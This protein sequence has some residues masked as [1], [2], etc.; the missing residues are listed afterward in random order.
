[1]NFTRKN[2]KPCEK[3]R[4]KKARID[5]NVKALRGDDFPIYNMIKKAIE[6]SEPLSTSDIEAI[7]K[8]N[9]IRYNPKT[10]TYG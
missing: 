3:L 9:L 10:K 8:P 5:E 6:D 7:K 2:C 1:M 4:E